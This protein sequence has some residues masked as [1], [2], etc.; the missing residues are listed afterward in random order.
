MKK[1]FQTALALAATLACSAAFA[2]GGTITFDSVLPNI[3]TNGDVTTE[4]N[5]V[6]TTV[7]QGGFDGSISDQSSCFLAICPSGNA[8]QFYAALND[9]GLNIKLFDGGLNL[10]GLDFGFVLPLSAALDFSVGQLLVTGIDALGGSTTIQRDF[11]L[12]DANGNYNFSH[13]DFDT[14]FAS[15]WFQSVTISSC[16]YDGNGGCVNPAENQ[17]QFAVDNIGYLPEPGSVALVGVSLAGLLAAK[18]RRRSV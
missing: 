15:S 12:Q 6:I 17:A 18:R 9:G 14:G 1:I 11:D 2:G 16:L 13:W 3:L 7:G 5:A 10:T 8:T 4:G